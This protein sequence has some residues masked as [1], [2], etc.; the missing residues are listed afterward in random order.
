MSAPDW[1]ALLGLTLTLALNL[2]GY[3]VAWGVLK[4]KVRTLTDKVAALEGEAGAVGDLRV[5]IVRIETRLDG[6]LEQFRD[7]NSAIRWMRAD[8]P[9]PFEPGPLS[10][11][12]GPRRAGGAGRGAG[13]GAGGRA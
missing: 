12:L 1:I 2:A 4:S 11:V 5:Q 8:A 9:P 6:L 13:R 10:G 3:L 7:L